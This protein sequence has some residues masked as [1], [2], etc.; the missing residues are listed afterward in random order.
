MKTTL[1]LF[2]ALIILPVFNC[3]CQQE[4]SF[5]SIFDEF[6]KNYSVFAATN[7]WDDT[8]FPIKQFNFTQEELKE[9]QQDENGNFVAVKKVDVYTVQEYY[10]RRLIENIYQMATHPDFLKSE[11]QN[12]LI[13]EYVIASPDQKMFDFVFPE[14]TGGTYDAQLSILYFVGQ[15]PFISKE[16]FL[17]TKGRMEKFNDA[18]E[19]FHPDGYSFIDTIQTQQG[20]KYVLKGGVKGCSSCFF[21]YIKL[22]HFEGNQFVT[23]FLY[24]LETRYFEEKINYDP[25]LK[26]ITVKYVTDDLTNFCNCDNSETEN[27]PIEELEN[28]PKY[29]VPCFCKFVFNGGT[30]VRD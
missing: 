8:S 30:F 3:Y 25:K 18:D 24:E 19:I 14:N 20:V 1:G 7:P 26:D 21:E 9:I 11:N 17:G 15:K 10:L 16:E 27:E 23:D 22:V 5:N 6:T 13:P 28:E 12:L 2:L 4:K 29:D